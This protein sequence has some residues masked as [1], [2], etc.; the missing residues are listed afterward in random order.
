M[1]HTY[2]LV[3]LK[4]PFY[5]EKERWTIAVQIKRFF[6]WIT[7]FYAEDEESGKKCIKDDAED[8]KKKDKILYKEI[9]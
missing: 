1:K 4:K 2:R 6:F 5:S 7:I 9:A 3:Q 8:K